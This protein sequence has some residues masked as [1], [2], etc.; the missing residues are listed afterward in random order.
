MYWIAKRSQCKRLKIP[1]DIDGDYLEAIWTGVCPVF[2]VQLNVPMLDARGHGSHNTA[3][4]DRKDP[5]LGYVKGNVFW[6]SGR[7][8]RIKYNATVE[9]LSSILQYMRA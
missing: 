7:A 3:H 4:L 1:T 2:N 9:E 5:D 6:I 8:N